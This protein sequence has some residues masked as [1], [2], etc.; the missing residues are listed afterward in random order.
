MPVYASQLLQLLDVGV[1]G[2]LKLVY[3]KLLE[4]CMVAGNNYIDKEDFLSLYPDVRATV[5]TSEKICSGFIEAGL[6]L[7]N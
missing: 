5:F 3:G 2:P 7:F 4:E 1:F 6:K